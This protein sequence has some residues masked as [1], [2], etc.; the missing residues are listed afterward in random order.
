M[1]MF[2]PKSMYI[3][4]YLRAIIGKVI[5][6]NKTTTMV[7][8][9]TQGSIMSRLLK[10]S[11]PF[12]LANCLQLLYNL[13]DMIIVGQFVGS[14]GLSAVSIGGELLHFV[15]FI[16][17]GFSQAGQIIIAQYVGKG[18]RKSIS[19]VVGTLLSFTTLL[20]IVIMF[21]GLFACEG[22]IRLM[23]TPDEAYD[24]ALSYSRICC[25]G[26][27]FIYGYNSVSNIMRGMGDSKRPLMF[28]GIAAFINLVLDLLFVAV[29]K[30]N[31]A[32][33]ALATVIG[34]AVSFII[35]IIY[36]YR[37]REAFGF[38]FKPQSFKIDVHLLGTLT[39]LGIPVTLQTIA[40]SVSMMYVSA[41][42]NSYGLVY[43]AVTGIS[44]KIAQI[45]NIVTTSMNSAGATMVGQ[46]F[47]AGNYHR[48]SKVIWYV[49]LI[50]I[51]F[52]TIVT[53]LLLAFPEQAFRLF[54]DDPE[55]ILVAMEVVPVIIINFFSAATRVP[56]CALVNGIGFASMNFVMG[57][58]DGVVVR[59]GLALIMGKILNMGVYGY[60]YGSAIA[61][62]VY[63]I[64]IMPYFLS[65]AWK[66]RKPVID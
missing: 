52:S 40:I 13:I 61:G 22:I 27:V 42:I 33:A 11:A 14:A 56:A 1:L 45:A 62:F 32:G 26:A 55:V 48:V 35:S 37:R 54:N 20:A 12:I 19:R 3:F 66:K 50:S 6:L 44:S 43:S 47:G 41:C 36:L 9:L 5:D 4:L 63:F 21:I 25:C 51:S 59:I 16:G 28:I 57:I 49:F 38:D 53:L 46:N 58:M 30:M 60:W 64:V 34:Q 2:V 31:A 29:F 17:M 65:G 24:Q 8:D 10:F 7:N 15:T 39:K 23:N 18:D